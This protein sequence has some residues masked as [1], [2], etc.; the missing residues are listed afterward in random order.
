VLRPLAALAVVAL[1]LASC[2]GEG[3]P[4]PPKLSAEAMLDRALERLPASGRAEIDLD[5]QLPQDPSE[6]AA[7]QLE[8]PFDSSGGAVPSFDLEGE[9]EAAGFGVEVSLVSTGDDAYVVFFGENYRVGRD[10]VAALGQRVQGFDPRSWFG[11]VEHAGTEEVSG[12]DAYRL[13]GPLDTEQVRA[14]LQ[15]LG[16]SG[17]DSS[18]LEGGTVEA[19]VGV[20]DGI[21]HRLRLSSDAVDLDVELSDLGEP[22]EIRPP[23]GGGF[24]PIEDLLDRIP[25]I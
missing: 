9:A 12:T 22:Q 10:R 21:I 16:F 25:G 15:A 23:P 6:R 11:S 17:V 14:D 20:D 1:L 8:G 24:Q 4:P 19:W 18:G 13:E 7:A 2:G 5:A 3:E